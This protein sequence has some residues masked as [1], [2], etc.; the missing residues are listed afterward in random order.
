MDSQNSEL[1]R[2]ATR[3][4]G[5]LEAPPDW[6][7]QRRKH[8]PP[9][10][11]PWILIGVTAAVITCFALAATLPPLV[12]AQALGDH[13]ARIEQLWYWFTI[14][15]A[16]PAVAHAPEVRVLAQA[17]PNP[18]GA[19]APRLP[20]LPGFNAP[21]LSPVGP[22]SFGIA[23]AP[24]KLRVEAALDAE[25][26]DP[27]EPWSTVHLTQG[28]AP[29][30]EIPPGFDI[31]TGFRNVERARALARQGALNIAALLFGSGARN[32]NLCF[33]EVRLDTTTALLIEDLGNNSVID[34]LTLVWS[35]AGRA[36]ALRCGLRE[37]IEL[38]SFSEAGAITD[39]VH[40]A[41]SVR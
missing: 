20:H 26:S 34:R 1:D 9:A 7:P 19:F 2:W 4:A 37:P 13:F 10:P 24:V 18:A 15:H 30:L 41:N 27:P 22:A 38:L 31:T 39:A 21:R 6:A 12:F 3:A 29:V 16:H 33:R 32:R 5:L 28:P 25:W 11:R 40:L 8:M 36:Y 23:N 14:I 35:D 17:A